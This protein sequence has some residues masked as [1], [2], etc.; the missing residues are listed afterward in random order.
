[1][2]RLIVSIAKNLICLIL[3][4]LHMMLNF[5]LGDSARDLAT[6]ALSLGFLTKTQWQAL[7]KLKISQMQWD[8]IIIELN[9]K[10]AD[11]TNI[12]KIIHAS[13]SIVF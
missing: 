3:E 12:E 7:S 8:R 4:V 1:M 11:L 5:C 10:A 13:G 2:T 6:N 9:L